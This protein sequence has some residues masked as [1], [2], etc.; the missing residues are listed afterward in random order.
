M[1][2]RDTDLLTRFLGCIYSFHAS[3]LCSGPG[4]YFHRKTMAI[5]RKY[6][7]A[8]NVLADDL[9]F[10]YL[11]ATLTAWGIPA[12]GKGPTRLADLDKIRSSFLE[13]KTNICQV[14][15]ISLLGMGKERV[16]QISR[17]LW[18]ILSGLQVGEQ[19]ER[20][21]ANSKA[22]HHLLP[23]LVPPIDSDY[24]LRFFY[25][26]R[27][28]DRE[29]RDIFREIYPLFYEIGQAQK[30]TIRRLVNEGRPMDTST[31][32]VIDNAIIGYVTE[33]M[34]KRKQKLKGPVQSLQ[35][36]DLSSPPQLSAIS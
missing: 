33:F 29:E 24:T 34:K 14:E 4:V 31:T 8:H 21:V 36:P 13:Q 18:E 9:F 2:D 12:L 5:R 15:R 1:L 28:I 7:L 11:Y 3:N 22:L 27:T 6:P 17:I 20:L 35:H 19:S 25:G 23:D 30:E 26:N 10:D 32:K 16:D